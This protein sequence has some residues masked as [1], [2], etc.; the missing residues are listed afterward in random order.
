MPVLQTDQA[1][2]LLDG[3]PFRILSGGLHYFRVHP[4]QWQDRLRKARLMGLNT[5]ETYVPWN[6][7]QPRPDRFVMDAG[8]DLPRFL[9]LAAAEG[10]HV[11]LRPGPYICAEWEGGGIP[12]RLLAEPDIRLRTRD[13]RFPAQ[14]IGTG[15]HDLEDPVVVVRRSAPRRSPSPGTSSTIRRKAL[16]HVVSPGPASG[17]N[18]VRRMPFSPR[19]IAPS[20]SSW[21]QTCDRVSVPLTA[22]RSSASTCA[23]KE[24]SASHGSWPPPERSTTTSAGGFVCCQVSRSAAG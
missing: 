13:P 22:S 21:A 4:D 12:S 15:R 23:M 18:A 24:R 6:L 5:V 8:L 9:D 7:H 1:G 19:V 11:L 14:R 17:P 2:F 10:L 20:A 3:H 16:R